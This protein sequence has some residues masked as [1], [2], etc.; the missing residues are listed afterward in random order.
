MHARM[1][2]RT[3]IVIGAAQGIGRAI[4]HRL[5]T[6]GASVVVADLNA[7]G[8]AE[9]ADA[10]PGE[11]T[12]MGVDVADAEALEALAAFTLARFGRIDILVQNAGI[13]PESLIA[14]TSPAQWQRV[15]A[16]NL[17]GS[18]YA[19]RAVLPAM[20]AQRYGRMVFTSSITGPRV[21]ASGTAAYSASKAGINGFIK[22]AALE[23]AG[24]G[25]TVNAVEPGNIMTEGLTAGRSADFID[26]MTRSIPIGRI[27]TPDD[28]AGAVAYLAS[29]EAGFVTGTSILIDG[30]QT[31]PE[32]KS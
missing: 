23:F 30:G 15:L 26:A 6:E 8:A 21:T 12:S 31:L 9:V 17:T 20:Q 24:F 10:L 18:F 27:G 22:T 28:V 5:A 7:Q 25:I 32:G 3:A 13:Y 14:E 19:C 16:V 29:A 2:G 1:A 11:A 4:A